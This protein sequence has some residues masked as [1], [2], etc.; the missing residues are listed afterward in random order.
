[1]PEERKSLE[2]FGHD[3]RKY[4]DYIQEWEHQ[5]SL[6]RTYPISGSHPWKEGDEIEEGKDFE[7]KEIQWGAGTYVDY[8]RVAIP[9]PSVTNEEDEL[10]YWKKRCEAAEKVL[11]CVPIGENPTGIN[12]YLSD[13]DERLKEW[14]LLTITNK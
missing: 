2:D 10:T 13:F 1:M 9:I 14:K 7:I 8:K 3:H 5:F 4:E 12:V 11:G 6:E